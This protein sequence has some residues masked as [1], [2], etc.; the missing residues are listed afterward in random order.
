MADNL[1]LNNSGATGTVIAAD[2]IGG[3]LH[4][5]SKVGF[6]ADGAYVDV[7]S[8]APLPTRNVA[9][10]LAVV[11]AAAARQLRASLD[12]D[13][14][15][16]SAVGDYSGSQGR[17]EIKP[18][19]A[20]H[21]LAYSLEVAISIAN[22]AYEVSALK[23]FDELP[24]ANGVRVTVRN[25]A[26]DTVVCYLTDPIT[27]AMEWAAYGDMQI[28]AG[29]VTSFVRISVPLAVGGMPI[30]LHSPSSGVGH[31]LSI[32]HDDDMAGAYSSCYYTLRALTVTDAVFDAQAI[33]VAT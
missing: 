7:S 28:E 9:A 16:L 11:G 10:G 13:G 26:D 33:E 25:L 5:R 31:Y 27:I 24:L 14:T 22:D 6:G 20:T 4:C 8:S 21:V 2:D 29:A 3:V 1:T 18:A 23:Y 17:F 32:D 30:D 19:A 12:A 15:T